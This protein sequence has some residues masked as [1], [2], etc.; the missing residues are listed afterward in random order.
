M[1]PRGNRIPNDLSA[2]LFLSLYQILS[3]SIYVTLYAEIQNKKCKKFQ[4]TIAFMKNV[5][6]NT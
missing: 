2:E 1:A 4:K 6:Y 5:C 3:V